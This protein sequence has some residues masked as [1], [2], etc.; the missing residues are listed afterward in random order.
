MKCEPT[1]IPEVLLITPDV[2][3][4]ARGFFIETYNEQRYANAGIDR[5]FVQD[6]YSHSR[7][8]TLRG[9]HY[10]LPHAQGK[11]ISVIWGRIFD[12]AVDIRQGSPSFGKWVGRELSEENRSQL[13]VP[14]G[15]AHGFMV[16]SERA[17]VQYKC[18]ELY[19]PEDDRGILWSDPAIGINWPAEQG[20][21][22]DKDQGLPLLSEIAP[23]QLPVF[24]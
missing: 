9:L 13:Y 8:G 24:E 22:S 20:I 6:N 21:L 5:H 19:H 2:F 10:Q 3:G 16:L 23:D 18:T 4:D 12:V 15:F 14:E 1:E 11:L 7:Q 17:D